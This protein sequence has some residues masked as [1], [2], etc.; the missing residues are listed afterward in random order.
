[1]IAIAAGGGLSCGL[2]PQLVGLARLLL[3][4]RGQAEEVV[5]EAFVRTYTGWKRVRRKDDPLPYLRSTIVNLARGGLRHR[6]VVRERRL[7]VVP[8]GESAEVS[9]ERDETYRALNDAVRGLP[10]RQRGLSCCATSSNVRRPSA[11]TRSAS[12]KGRSRRTCIVPWPRS[13]RVWRNCDDASLTTRSCTRRCIR[14]PERRYHRRAAST[15]CA[16]LRRE[17][18]TGVVL[19]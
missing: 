6:R 5:Q 16:P 18:D 17:K 10:E 9:F 8:D 11:R 7:D 4:D 13:P 14:T 15:K 12:P 3:D 2:H 19:S 1:M